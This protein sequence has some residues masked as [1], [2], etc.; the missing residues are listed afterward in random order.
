MHQ[1]EFFYI[2]I[3]YS[4]ESMILHD[5]DK[6]YTNE[7]QGAIKFIRKSNVSKNTPDTS[8]VKFLPQLLFGSFSVA[9]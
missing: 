6:V 7:Y 8:W 3:K 5:N 1:V 2:Y 9:F 4:I